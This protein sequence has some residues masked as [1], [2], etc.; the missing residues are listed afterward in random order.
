MLALGAAGCRRAEDHA[1][2]RRSTVVVPYPYGHHALSPWEDE[3][4]KF[5]M[6][7]PLV[8]RDARGNLEGRLADRWEHS[9]DY[10]EWTY[11]LRSDVRWHDGVPVTARDI[12]F[13]AA[14]TR[15]MVDSSVGDL[16]L[17][18]VVDERTVKIRHSA[19]GEP[20]WWAVYYPKHL[21]QGLDLATWHDWDYWRQPVGNGPYRFV[22]YQPGT[23]MELEAN[24][25]YYRGKPRIERVV[26]RFFT[27]RNTL[28]ELLAGAVDVLPDANATEIPTIAADPRFRVYQGYQGFSHN[29]IYWRNDHPLFRDRRVRLALTLAINRRELAGVLNFPV[30]LPIFDGPYTVDQIRRGDL[31]EALPYDPVRAKRLLDE[32]EW[33]IVDG[34]GIRQRDGRPFRFSAL[35]AGQVTQPAVY[36]QGQLR[37]IGVAMDIQPFE[38]GGLVRERMLSRDF[39]AAFMVFQ[40]RPQWLRQLFGTDSPVGYANADVIRLTEQWKITSDPEQLDR[41]QREIAQIFRAD[42]P[43]T[44]LFPSVVTTF[45]HRRIHGLSSPWRVDLFESIDDLSIED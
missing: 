17:V 8:G 5:L 45:A 37:S 36:V 11:R 30:N 6:F 4:P 25:D 42:L 26:L 10:R 34:D 23:M 18:T 29:A 16:G 32:A 27:Q 28:T 41:L 9:A 33:R 13:T 7:L 43:V 14:L 44:F 1:Y 35:T 12:E 24:P 22:R 20:A 40:P 39:E 15:R 21:L 2:S 19:E 31:P 3:T 38:G